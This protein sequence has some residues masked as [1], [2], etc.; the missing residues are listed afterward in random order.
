MHRE[1]HIQHEAKRAACEVVPVNG[2]LKRVTGHLPGGQE[3]PGLRPAGTL[4]YASIYMQGGRERERREWQVQYFKRLP[5]KGAYITDDLENSQGQL[6]R[7]GVWLTADHQPK[8][9]EKAQNF[10]RASPGYRL[11]LVGR[12]G[13]DEV[14]KV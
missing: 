2:R 9:F 7:G 11:V 6:V 14:V 4:A 8:T 5:P 12:G 10:V 3:Y 1:Q 13:R